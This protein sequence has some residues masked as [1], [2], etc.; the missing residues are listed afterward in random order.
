MIKSVFKALSIIMALC[1]F[2]GAMPLVTFAEDTT[3]YTSEEASMIQFSPETKLDIPLGST[4]NKFYS[5]GTDVD[6]TRFFYNQL[7]ANQKELYNQ[8]LAAGPVETISIDLT[9]INIVGMSKTAAGNNAFQ[10][11]MLAFSAINED[12]PLHCWASGFGIAY[13]TTIVSSVY[14]ISVLIVKVNLD[15]THFADFAEVQTKLD[16]VNEKLETIKINGISYHEKYK[17][18]HDYLANNIV[19]DSTIAE[20]NIYDVY[21]ALITGVCVCE[22]YAEAFKLL[23][24]R[25]GLPCITVVGTGNGGAHKWNM[26][27]MEDGEWY[28]LDSTWDD[29]TSYIYYSYFLIGSDTKAPFFS[30]STVADS[31]IHIPTGKLFTDCNTALSYPTLSN[32]TYGVGILAPNT[33][34]IHFD[35]ARNVLMVGKGITNYYYSFIDPDVYYL[36]DTNTFDTTRNGT[37]VTT[38]TFTVTDGTTTINYLVAMR[39]DINASNTTTTDDYNLTVSTATAKNMVTENTAKFYAGDMTQ[40]GAIDGFDAIALDLYLNDT[41]TFD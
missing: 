4:M 36:D 30:G 25:E 1:L 8:I 22:G 3:L 34:D 17:S 40:D 26:V 12:N 27:Q 2:I 32:D 20:P 18:I 9:N 7:T 31:T 5:N 11:L 6:T 38:S 21:G 37:G 39:G 41:I 10:D 24:D 35:R 15:T 33:K 29:Q 19:Y 13:D 14:K 28:T 23:C 16:A